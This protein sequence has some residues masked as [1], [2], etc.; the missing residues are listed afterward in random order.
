MK[1]DRATFQPGGAWFFS[2]LAMGTELNSTIQEYPKHARPC[3]NEVAQQA[4]YIAC[5]QY[6]ALSVT[7]LKFQ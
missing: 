5:A 7:S 4:I 3:E 1:A 6:I 2:I